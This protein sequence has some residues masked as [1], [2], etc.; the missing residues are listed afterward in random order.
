LQ[1]AFSLDVQMV[2]SMKLSFVANGNNPIDIGLTLGETICFGSLE[3]TT[4]R[5]GRLSLSPEEGDSGAIFIGMVHSGLPSLHIALEDSSDKG[6]AT[7]STGGSSES[8]SPRGCNV[9]TPTV[10][11]SATLAPKN[12][13][14]HLDDQGADRCT[15]VRYGA[16]PQPAVDLPGEGVSMNA[17]SV[18]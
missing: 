6:G 15:T 16:P 13:L 18:D 4:D 7:L 17:R 14:D 12:T 9:V 8:P 1:H 11:I 5:L 3:F 10:P 2:Y